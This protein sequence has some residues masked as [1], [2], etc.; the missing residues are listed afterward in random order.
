MAFRAQS[1]QGLTQVGTQDPGPSQ[2]FPF[3]DCSAA[4]VIPLKGEETEARPGVL[5]RLHKDLEKQTFSRMVW[6][7]ALERQ[8]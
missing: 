1:S 3:L 5:P 6:A 8:S 4:M 7:V 2:P